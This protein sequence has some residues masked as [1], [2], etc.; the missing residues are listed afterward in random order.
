MLF[1]SDADVVRE[2]G[3]F[4]MVK[5]DLTEETELSASVRREFD[6]RGVPTVILFGPGGTE[7]RRMIGYIGPDEMLAAMRAVR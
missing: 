6:V 7:H 3:R 4:R 5:A 2:A 1:R